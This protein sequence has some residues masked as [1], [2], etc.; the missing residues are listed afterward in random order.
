MNSRK[1]AK[2]RKFDRFGK[3]LGK[4]KIELKVF[5]PISFLILFTQATSKQKWFN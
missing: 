5:F 1:T 4:L 2:K 3:L